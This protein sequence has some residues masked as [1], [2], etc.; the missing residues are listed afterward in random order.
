MGELQMAEEGD[1]PL[2]KQR[3]RR[4]SK[5]LED[6]VMN[7]LGPMLEKVFKL[8]DISGDGQLDKK[9]LKRAFELAEQ[10]KS[11]EDIQAAI[12]KLDQDNDGMISLAEFKRIA[13]VLSVQGKPEDATA[14]NPEP[15]A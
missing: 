15:I 13:W 2:L 12:K 4:K 3:A 9:E 8:M 10:P 1:Y 7:T 5:D 11:Q 6:Q 14:A